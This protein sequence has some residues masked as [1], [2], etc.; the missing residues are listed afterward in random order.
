MLQS[1]RPTGLPSRVVQN[2][3]RRPGCNADP[4]RRAQVDACPRLGLADHGAYRQA[5]GRMRWALAIRWR[6]PVVVSPARDSTLP[7]LDGSVR[8]VDI[9]SF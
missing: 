3:R 2:W 5:V 7:T 9:I 1:H 8:R 4:W 6:P